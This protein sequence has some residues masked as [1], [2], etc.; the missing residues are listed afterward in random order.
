MK[1]VSFFGTPKE[2]FKREKEMKELSKEFYIDE[3][4]RRKMREK[5][6]SRK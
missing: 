5:R 6:E 2:L 3:Q 1:N 4:N